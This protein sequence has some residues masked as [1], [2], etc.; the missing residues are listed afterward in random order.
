MGRG[1]RRKW[2]FVLFVYLRIPFCSVLKPTFGK[3]LHTNPFIIYQ[4]HVYP[5]IYLF[6]YHIHVNTS[7][8]LLSIIFMS[9][10]ISIF[11]LSDWCLFIYLS[12]IYQIYVYPSIYLLSIRFM[13]IHIFM[14]LFYL[15]TDISIYYKYICQIITF[16]HF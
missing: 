3:P 4:I 6:I 13:S 5:S 16:D 7:I 9:I 2:F 10:H 14:I 8:Y 11:Y 15:S 1:G 12:F